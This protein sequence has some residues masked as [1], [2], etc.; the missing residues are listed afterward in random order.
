MREQPHYNN[1]LTKEF[2]EEFYINKK[3][4][5]PKL[6]EMLIEKGYN[7][8]VGT[9]QRYAKKYNI[10]RNGSES[11]RNRDEKCLDYD[12]TYITDDIIEFLDGFLLGDGGISFDKRNKNSL[13]AR[14]SCGVQYE[15][16]CK[17]LMKPFISLGSSVTKVM[18]NS[19]KQGFGFGGRTRSHPD[20]YKQ[21]LR[22]YPE[23]NSKRIKQPPD[24]IRITPES[25][26]R[27][28]LGDGSCVSRT[29]S[30]LVRLSTDG[31][32]PDKVEFLVTK[33][34][35]KG[36]LCHRS[37]E[38]RIII[39]AKGIPSFFNFIGRKSPIKCYDYKFDKID[40]WRLESK[41]MSEVAK[42]LNI[43]Y[44]KLAYFVKIGKINCYRISK[45][46]KPRFL[47]E[48]IEEIKKLIETGQIY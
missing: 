33:L 23:S 35:E 16:F 6:R 7:I 29:N 32:S 38:N 46:G 5:Y 4:S 13:V 43:D 37:N 17:Y 2:F 18:S 26:M 12:K 24:D 9:L 47:I 22:W 8:H 45:K 15:E 28:F 30:I 25:V 34:L 44:Q 20:I 40:N 36:I 11:R 39:N 48:H 27:W 3:L 42:E 21:Y 1:L 10:G 14:F 19:F 41:R 31:F